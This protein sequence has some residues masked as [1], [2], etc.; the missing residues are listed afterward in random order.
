MNIFIFLLKCK[1]QASGTVY[2]GYYVCY[3]LHA[4]TEGKYIKNL[5][6]HGA[7]VISITALT[8]RL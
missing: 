7:D 8:Y 3:Y 2:Y 5:I 1:K 6:E 4:N